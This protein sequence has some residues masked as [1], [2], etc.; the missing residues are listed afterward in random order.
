MRSDCCRRR[1]LFR[2]SSLT[3][4]I[5]RFVPSTFLDRKASFPFHAF[6]SNGFRFAPTRRGLRWIGFEAA[7]SQVDYRFTS[8]GPVDMILGPG[9]DTAA[10]EGLVG[11]EYGGRAGTRCARIGKRVMSSLGAV[12]MCSWRRN[13]SNG[14]W[15]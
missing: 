11:G 7:P 15:G 12:D 14:E 9:P 1:R 2:A 8:D 6:P 5:I 10:E 13:I 4:S 3:D